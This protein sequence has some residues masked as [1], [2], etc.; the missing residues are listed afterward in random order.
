MIAQEVQPQLSSLAN[1]D[2]QGKYVCDVIELIHWA[3]R[4]LAGNVSPGW[5]LLRE[6]RHVMYSG[7]VGC[8]R[9]SDWLRLL[10]QSPNVQS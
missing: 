5:S 4:V 8:E 7:A 3:V 6:T 2:V 10:N 1:T 9:V